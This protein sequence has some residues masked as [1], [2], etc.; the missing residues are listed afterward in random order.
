MLKT[1]I[2]PKLLLVIAL[3]MAVL[4]VGACGGDDEAEPTAAPA[5]TATTAPAAAAPTAEPTPEEVMMEEK[6]APVKAGFTRVTPPPLD[7]PTIPNVELASEQTLVWYITGALPVSNAPYQEGSKGAMYMPWTY[8]TVFLYAP[9]GDKDFEDAKLRQG[10]AVA[11]DVSDDTETYILHLARDATFTSGK[12]ITAADVKLAWEFGAW[13]ANQVTWGGSLIQ[14]RQIE[15]FDAVEEGDA[16]E[17]SGL[18]VVDDHTLQIN[19]TKPNPVFPL[20]MTGTNVGLYD[21]TYAQDNPTDWQEH[22]VGVGPYQMTYDPTAG[23]KVMVEADS[24]WPVAPLIKRVELPYVSDEQTNLIAYEAGDADVM[25]AFAQPALADPSHPLSGD[26]V[27]NAGGGGWYWGLDATLP[28][29]D[30]LNVRKALNHALDMGAIAEALWGPGNVRPKGVILAGINCQ[31]PAAKGYPFDPDKA[32]EFLAQSKYAG[33][34]PTITI[35]SRDFNPQMLGFMELAQA[36][37]EKELGIEVK[38]DLIEPGNPLPKADQIKQASWGSSIPDPAGMLSR[39]TL[40]GEAS[41]VGRQGDRKD[42]E[43][44]ALMNA[45]LALDFTDPG[46]CAAMQKV[47]TLFMDRYYWAPWST[48][49]QFTSV[50]QPWVLGWKATWGKAAASLPFMKIGKRDRD[51][52]K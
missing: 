43:L 27:E 47:E 24:P 48:G 26:R 39:I 18:V 23:N 21:A 32:R 15:G 4:L 42:D 49:F 7:P 36:G 10:V 50:V 35:T 9:D 3:S 45:A 38:I 30:D 16:L 29:T 33:D 44:D 11:Y 28:P 46:R 6:M 13:P 34:V 14:L 25:E 37:W 22:P 31:N 19:L 52:Y 17:A 40:A 20:E 5:T 1:L 41:V 51:L 12:P 2:S 8:M